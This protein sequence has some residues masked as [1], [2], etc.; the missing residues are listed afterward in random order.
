[1]EY[2]QTIY[3]HLSKLIAEVFQLP[4]SRI[5]SVQSFFSIVALPGEKLD[6]RQRIPH[7]DIPLKT[8]IATIHFLCSNKFGGTSFYR[9]KRTGYE[10]IDK[11]R[12]EPYS[13][14]LYKEIRNQGMPKPVYINGDTAQYQR[15]ASYG[16]E[17]NRILIYRSSSLHSG[18]IAPDYS[19]DPDP[20]AGRLSVTSFIKGKD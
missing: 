7:F 1:M 8:G 20:R 12:V 6:V 17:F 4:Q 19:L 11:S 5:Q 2:M 15:I 9:H 16:A 10:F 18:D 3:G 13:D 14:V